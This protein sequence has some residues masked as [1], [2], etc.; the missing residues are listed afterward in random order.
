MKTESADS[1]EATE[2]NSVNR[3]PTPAPD[4]AH[5]PAPLWLVVTAFATVYLVWGSTYLG[6]RYAVQSIPP[7]MMAGAR[8]FVAGLILFTFTRFRR[9]AFP[10]WIEWRDAAIAGTLM[11]VI[12]N[13]GVTW[14]EQRIPSGVAALLVALVPLWMVVLDWLRPGGARP[15]PWVGVGLLIGIAGVALLARG[16]GEHH[17]AAYGWSVAALMIAS[18]SWAWGSLFSRCARKPKSPLLGVA[19]QMIAGGAVLLVLAAAHGEFR[20]FA[21]GDVTRVSFGSWLYLTI[22]GSLIAYTAYVWILQVSTPARVATYAYVN[23]LIAVL[24]GCTLGREAFSHELIL[25]AA[26][27]VL[28]VILI[29]RGGAQSN[30]AKTLS[31]TAADSKMEPVSK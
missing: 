31:T 28:A 29:V 13:G 19:M 4:A 6:I 15:R 3:S 2:H 1:N 27:I 5:K 18:I 21:F 23:P 17:E 8:H 16:H 24:L 26:L 10:G 7:F 25:A 11:L 20:R 30:G 14:A 9:V 12:G 22:A